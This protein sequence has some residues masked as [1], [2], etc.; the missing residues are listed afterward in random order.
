[1]RCRSCRKEI[2]E[3]AVYCQHCGVKQS[4]ARL[5]KSRGNGQ[6]SAYKLPNGKW[7]AA[8]L[9]GYRTDVE[10]KIHRKVRCKDGFKTKREA[11]EYIPLLRARQERPKSVTLKELYDRWEVLPAALRSPRVR[12]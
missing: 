9:V 1:M 5:P 3:G 8:V 4:V 6:G 11:L 2:P 7:R 10:G 12:H